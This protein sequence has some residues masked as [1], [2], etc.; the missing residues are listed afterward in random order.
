VINDNELNDSE[1]VENKTNPTETPVPPV[2]M[3]PFLEPQGSGGAGN[4]HN[5]ARSNLCPANTT[6]TTGIRLVTVQRIPHRGGSTG[7]SRRP[8]RRG[9]PRIT[10]RSAAS[11]NRSSVYRA[12]SISW[13][14]TFPWSLSPLFRGLRQAKTPA[15]IRLDPPHEEIKEPRTK[16]F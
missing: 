9:A 12:V 7:Q 11:K 10:Q 13:G 3:L 5:C 8:T 15:A 4:I 1:D 6:T 14:F 2:I 16:C